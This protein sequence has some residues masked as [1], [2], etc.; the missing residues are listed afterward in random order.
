VDGMSHGGCPVLTVRHPEH[1]FVHPSP[2]TRLRGIIASHRLL[3]G[4]RGNHG[5]VVLPQLPPPYA[6]L[7]VEDDHRRV[8]AA[9]D[10]IHAVRRN[11]HGGKSGRNLAKSRSGDIAVLHCLPI[12]RARI[13]HYHFDN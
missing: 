12:L 4:K 3:A 6:A 9:R 8:V 13:R 11:R 5:R 1:E 2:R 10:D 7:G